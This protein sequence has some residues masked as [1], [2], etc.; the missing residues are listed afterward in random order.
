M[1]QSGNVLFLILIAVA[2]FAALSYAVT[3][4]TSGG[5][6]VTSET[7]RLQAS[8]ILQSSA[9]FKAGL[10]RFMIIQGFSPKQVTFYDGS[11]G[12]Y[13]N[14]VQFPDTQAYFHADG[15]GGS[16]PSLPK[17]AES[18][19]IVGST[20]IPG[21]GKST[22]CTG[23][24]PCAELT[25]MLIDVPLDTCMAIND[26]GGVVNTNGKPPV[27]IGDFEDV[28]YQASRTSFLSGAHMFD[29]TAGENTGKEFACFETLHGYRGGPGKYYFYYHLVTDVHDY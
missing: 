4:S 11:G 6:N 16:W 24:N 12:A 22:A 21:F 28:F 18:W 20:S 7:S 23:A 27:D 26:L 29:T 8:E 13:L 3:K 10:D 15:F 1:R 2:L 5:G 9:G 17:G 25:L 14:A 19:K